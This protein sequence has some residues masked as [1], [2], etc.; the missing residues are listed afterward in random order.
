MKFI[1][2]IALCITLTSGSPLIHRI[3]N[4]TTVQNP[5]PWMAGILTY[6]K[7]EGPVVTFVR[8]CG[9]SLIAHNWVLTARHCIYTE[10][11]QQASN[12]FHVIVGSNTNFLQFKKVVEIHKYNK[13]H[14]DDVILL[15]LESDVVGIAPVKVQYEDN[16]D[17]TG[18]MA[19]IY[20]W[21]ITETHQ[22]SQDLRQTN[23]ELISREECGESRWVCFD[24]ELTNSNACGGD[25]GGPMV[26][27]ENGETLLIGLAHAVV[28]W[29][30]PP[31]GTPCE[32]PK[33]LYMS[34]AHYASWIRSI[35]G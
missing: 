29:N 1:I 28:V 35:I 26:L 10:K 12:E 30:P 14:E 15:K 17:Y 19:T 31:S 4:G 32:G 24:P 25:S 22:Q 13:D 5:V 33:S 2:A 11:E 3:V 21:G 8:E 16:I 23:V 27:E 34:T 7:A 9:G 20:G 18:K 6:Y